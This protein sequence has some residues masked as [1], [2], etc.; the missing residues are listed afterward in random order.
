MVH[1]FPRWTG[2]ERDG[3]GHLQEDSS[4][5]GGEFTTPAGG[6]EEGTYACANCDRSGGL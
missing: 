4:V 6:G 3:G 1:R 5:H 2:G